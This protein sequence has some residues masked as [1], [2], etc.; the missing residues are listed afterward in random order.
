MSND[1]LA[2]ACLSTTRERSAV[3]HLGERILEMSIRGLAVDLGL[4]K[5]TV[6]RALALLRRGG[7][8]QARQTR[9]SAG[10]FARGHYVLAATGVIDDTSPAVASVT[11]NVDELGVPP[12][13]TL[14][15][16]PGAQLT[17]EL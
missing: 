12:A 1:R 5:N 10:T 7:L 4:A 17:L 11:P 16:A 2:P 3:D 14:V 15:S 8:I 6:H 9:A 13:M